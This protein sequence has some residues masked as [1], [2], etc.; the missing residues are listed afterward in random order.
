MVHEIDIEGVAVLGLAGLPPVEPVVIRLQG[1]ACSVV[2]AVIPAGGY[3][4]SGEVGIL[5]EDKGRGRSH[6]RDARAFAHEA[7]ID[8][9]LDRQSVPAA[10]GPVGAEAAL[11]PSPV[12]EVSA[13]G[14]KFGAAGEGL[15]I[16]PVD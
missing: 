10:G 7:A 6:C 16:D 13:I 9:A 5:V 15:A 8:V 2:E 3:V 1:E 11:G 12:V 14:V 4:A